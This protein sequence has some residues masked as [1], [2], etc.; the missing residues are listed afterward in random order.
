M[1]FTTS[2]DFVSMIEIVSSARLPAHTQRPSGVTPTPSHS[3]PVLTSL[4]FCPVLKSNAL[5]LPSRM[6]EQ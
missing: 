4:I 5:T 6:F 1:R 3:L 2:S